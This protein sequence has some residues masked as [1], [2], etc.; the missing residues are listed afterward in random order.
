MLW[1]VAVVVVGALSCRSGEQP[2]DSANVD[3]PNILWISCEDISADLGCYG[4]RYARTPNIDRLAAEG[5]RY[6]RVFTCAPVCAPNRSG[7][8]TGMWPTTIGTH[9]MRCRAV[10]PP[11]VRCFTE[12]LREAGYYCTNN[13][14]TDYNFDSPATAWDESSRSAHW[15]TAP[16]GRPFFAVINLTTTHESQIR[17][18]DDVFARRTASLAPGER[19]DPAEADLPPYYP[20]TPVVRRDWARYYDLIT[21]MDKQVGEIL[22]DLEQDGLADDTIVF[23]WSDHGRG[24]PRGKR[25]L[26]DSGIHVPLIVRFPGKLKAGTTEER[27]VSSIDLGPTVL[28]LAG[29]PVPEHMQGRPFLGEQQAPPRRYIFA[30]RDRMDEAYDIIR[31]VRDERFKYFRNYE[32]Y[33]PY[34]QPINYMDEMPTMQELRRLHAAGQLAGPRRLFF[35]PAKPVE[36]LFDTKEDPHEIHDLANN[37]DREVLERLRAAHER[38]RL[39]TRDLGLIPEGEL[40]QRMRPGGNWVVTEAPVIEPAGGRHDGHVTVRISCP[41]KGARIAYTTEEGDDAHWQLYHH[42]IELRRTATLRAKAVRIGYRE[43]PVATAR[44]QVSRTTR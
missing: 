22:R 42:P 5:V 2:R 24:L 14:K 36:E 4:D 23:F 19:H 20:D 37:P 7:I 6:T 18:A 13:V 11:Y 41:T 21:A 39:E 15:R 30:A 44:F 38:W 43:S 25:W 9:H 12:Y 33:R 16:D 17:T 31:V 1:S 3:R 34:A 32:P 26:Y 28:S 35:R 8:I 27:L 10:P 40:W 29:V